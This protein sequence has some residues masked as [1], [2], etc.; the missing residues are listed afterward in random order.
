MGRIAIEM[1]TN[2]LALAKGVQTNLEEIAIADLACIQ[3]RRRAAQELYTC[4]LC[5]TI[6]GTVLYASVYSLQGSKIQILTFLLC[7]WKI[8]I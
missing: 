1:L 7:T 3:T 5:E 2:T 4:P 6:N 8:M